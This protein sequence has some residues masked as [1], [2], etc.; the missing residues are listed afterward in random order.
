MGREGGVSAAWGIGATGRFVGG[1]IRGALGGGGGGGGTTG[2]EGAA[3]RA[4]MGAGA[5]EPGVDDF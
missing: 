4:G 2:D 5:A 3:G 1:V